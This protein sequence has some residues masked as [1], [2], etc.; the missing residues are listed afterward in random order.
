MNATNLGTLADLLLEQGLL[1]AG[2]PLADPSEPSR[3]VRVLGCAHDSRAVEPGNVFV[4][5]GVRFEPR[6]LAAAEAAGAVA[7]VCDEALAGELARVAPG[8]PQLACRDV[9]R[10]MSLVARAAWGYP[11]RDLHVVGV[12]GTKGKT[13]VTYMLRSILDGDE[14]GSRAGLL[15]SVEYYDGASRGRSP[16]TTPEAP[17]LFRRLANAADHGLTMVMEVSSQG[18]KYGRVEGVSF[19]VAALTNIGRDHISP[20]EHPTLEDYVASKMRSFE[21]AGSAVVQLGLMGRDDVAAACEGLEVTTFDAC[22]PAADVWASDVRP[23]G[24][25]T[26]FTAHVPGW[27]RA[28]SVALPGSF[29]VENALCAIAVAWRLGV[30]ADRIAAGLARTRV[31]G[32]M[33]RVAS[34]SGDLVAIVDYAHNGQSFERFFESVREQYPGWPV[35]SVFGCTGVK[36]LERRLQMPPVAARDSRLLV[37]TEDDPGTEPLSDI[38]RDMVSVTP[39]DARYEVVEDRTRAIFRA[40]EV[41]GGWAAEEGR[42]LVCLLGKGAEDR[43]LTAEG[44]V[45]RELD[46]EVVARAIRERDARR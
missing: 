45:P 35:V 26:A 18:L 29:N 34:E 28:M 7:Y 16:N 43:M 23:E 33:E 39:P 1:A 22:D 8:L 5:K 31:P 30:D 4:C 13:T 46:A 20:V 32:R 6:F 15:G 37:Y 41:A 17:E 44:P 9:R 2:S 24:G 21:H 27:E 42:A 12:T 40:V 14:P 25:G 19:D 10:A 36:G 38:I 11:D 3:D